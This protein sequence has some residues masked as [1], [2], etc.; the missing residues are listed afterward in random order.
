MNELDAICAAEPKSVL[1]IGSGNGKFLLDAA[2]RIEN[3]FG[4]D[5]ARSPMMPELPDNATFSQ[6]DVLE[7]DDLP[8]ADI[9]CSADV[10]EHFTPDEISV[11]VPKLVKLSKFQYHVIACYDNHDNHLTVMAPG[12]W[13]AL[14]RKY[15]KD[16][17]LKDV[18]IRKGR[19]ENIICTI[20]N[21]PQIDQ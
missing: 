2:K 17:Y 1:E 4:V 7:T 11:L 6:C 19:P 21:I 10:L 14:F 3:V 16:F 18:T 12:A 8:H 5:L 9:T 15:G 20:T 13:L